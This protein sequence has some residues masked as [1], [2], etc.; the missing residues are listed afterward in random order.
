[1]RASRLVFAFRLRPVLHVTSR[2]AGASRTRSFRFSLVS[3]GHRAL[4]DTVLI[5]VVAV[6]SLRYER[7][8]SAAVS[9]T[10]LSS[11]SGL[12]R[13]ASVPSDSDSSADVS[14]ESDA[15]NVL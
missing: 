8:R 9:S 11:R 12:R 15:S 7:V 2:G 13:T 10:E 6:G 5:K 14:T 3:L 4:V 1:V